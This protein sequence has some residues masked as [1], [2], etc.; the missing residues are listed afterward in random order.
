[1]VFPFV[2]YDIFKNLFDLTLNLGSTIKNSLQKL[3]VRG[4]VVD[5][6]WQGQNSEQIGFLSR[7]PLND[8][9]VMSIWR[10]ESGWDLA[11]YDMDKRAL[12]YLSQDNVI[13]QHP[14]FDPEGKRILFTADYDG[15]YNIYQLD[16]SSHELTRLTNVEGG[17][18]HPVLLKGQLYYAGY[19]AEGFDVFVMEDIAP[20]VVTDKVATP[21]E[22][23]PASPPVPASVATTD[24]PEPP[25]ASTSACRTPTPGSDRSAARRGR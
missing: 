16:L 11:L 1:M 8:S 10:P 5:T 4:E 12:T 21:G 23:E 7:S 24:F 20:E 6:L 25:R 9:L 14:V 17:A 3:N 15:V 2:L 22:T 18:F 13:Q 19:T